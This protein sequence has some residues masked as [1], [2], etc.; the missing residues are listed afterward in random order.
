[1][2]FRSK[3][4]LAGFALLAAILASPAEAFDGR[5]EGF[6]LGASVGYG[7]L[8][9]PQFDGDHE[10]G[11]GIAT[12]LEIG[13]GLDERWILHY[14]GRQILNLTG[15]V[16]YTQVFPMI[17]ATYYLKDEAR[18][19]YLTGGGGVGFFTGFGSDDI[20]GGFTFFGGA[21]YEF[22]PHWRVEADYVNTL[23][24]SGGAGPESTHT[25]L[26][27]VGTLAY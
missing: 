5:R 22:A 25:L 15:D 3:A 4:T 20:S 6:V 7:W 11:N 24:T 16:S 1:M 13:V 18:S 2:G 21:G 26:V 27:T 12:R 17:A 9:V 19:A 10:E 23:D 8:W 14:S